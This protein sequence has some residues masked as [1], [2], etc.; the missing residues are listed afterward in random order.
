MSSEPFDQKNKKDLNNS[1][2]RISVVR[3]LF[4]LLA[5]YFGAYPF[6]PGC[7][8][9]FVDIIFVILSFIHI[10]YIYNSRVNI[11][12]LNFALSPAW[13]L[14]SDPCAMVFA[15]SYTMTN[16][17]FIAV[18]QR[19][20]SAR[21]F[22]M[23]V[24]VVSWV[25]VWIVKGTLIQ[26]CS[27]NMTA[28]LG[29]D[30]TTI[31]SRVLFVALA[32]FNQIDAQLKATKDA[33][34][35]VQELNSK[36]EKVNTELKQLLDDKD[37][38]I[39]LFSHE[40]RNPLNIL[41]GNLTLLLDEV[42]A[43]QM[44]TKLARCKFCADLLLQHLNNILDTGKLANK[45]TLEV[46]PT[47]VRIYEYIQSTFM[48][49]E[50]LVKKKKKSNSLK[51]EL[52]I[53]QKL[54]TNLKF[55]IQRLTQVILNLLTNAVKFTESGSIT[56]VVR[57]L[58]KGEIEESDYYPTTGFGYLLLNKFGHGNP[59]MDS[60]AEFGENPL[61]SGIQVSDHF[62]REMCS[63]E[64]KKHLIM[65]GDAHERGYLKIEVYDTGC[66]MKEEELNKL[67]IK[68]SQTHA[69]GSQRQIGS[70]LGLWITKS[71]CEL[72]EGGIRVYSKPD[73]GTCFSAIIQAD[74]LPNTTR[75]AQSKLQAST[76]VP[77]FSLHQRRVLI[78]DDDPYNLDLHVA[79]IKEL[80]FDLIETASN[81]QE[82]LNKFKVKPE[83]YYDIVVTDVA[84]PQIDGIQAALKIRE[85]ERTQKR[86]DNVKIGFITGHS[87]TRDK[88]RCEKDPI[89]AHFYLPT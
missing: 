43:P 31:L 56:M 47:P 2:T 6:K 62:R 28:N 7:L 88:D 8:L 38:F 55:D 58:K 54:P 80:G 44:K 20:N 67:F 15:Q 76:R 23:I 51:P 78:A 42:E 60:K 29:R 50:M 79:I 1:F 75:M 30:I 83:K 13:I 57:H 22:H 48:F 9:V 35:Q 72:M 86:R 24:M 34:S 40:T 18:Q 19:S 4:D 68:F 11:V 87:N 89:L 25:F 81:G 71:L 16:V 66:G 37:N 77:N 27:E 46:A 63:M 64:E 14:L 21:A 33:L 82:L 17:F 69:E 74:S 45:G 49:M 65:E 59:R 5:T 26:E 53:P 41:L 52:I 32:I 84:M 70:G 73:M 36:F 85:F 10:S 39:L 61:G 3:L 12:N